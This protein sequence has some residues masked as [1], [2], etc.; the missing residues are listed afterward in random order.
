MLGYNEGEWWVQDIS[1]SLAANYF[2]NIQGKRILDLC[3]APGGKTSQLI[4]MGAKVTSLDASQDRLRI[5]QQNLQRLK[6]SAEN[7]ICCDAV[8]YLQNFNKEPYDGILLD[9]PC[10]ATG[11]FRRHPEIVHLKKQED[12]DKQASLQKKILSVISPALKTGG[13]LIYC[14]C[15]I[16]K[17]EGEEQILNFI[18]SHNNYKIIPLKNPSEPQSETTEG[19]I[20]TLPFHYCAQQGCDAFFIAKLTKEA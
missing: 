5:L 10:S 12:I 18:K 20:R 2:S 11:V 15:S 16:A 3:A 9:A 19:F 6:L 4:S 14:T 8:D 17:T 7:I 13:E 1:A